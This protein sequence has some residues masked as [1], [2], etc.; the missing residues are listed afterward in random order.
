MSFIQVR[1]CKNTWALGRLYNV[2]YYVTS[3]F[4]FHPCLHICINVQRCSTVK[5]SATTLFKLKPD[6][7]NGRLSLGHQA[8]VLQVA[9]HPR[10]FLRIVVN[11]WDY[12]WCQGRPMKMMS[13]Y[14]DLKG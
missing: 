7:F 11:L 3:L 2:T 8:E 10:F 4:E 14:F 6:T 9:N 13:N 5:V 12:T 1:R